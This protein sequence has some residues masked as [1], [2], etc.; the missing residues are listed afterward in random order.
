[1]GLFIFLPAT[2]K[3]DFVPLLPEVLP[4]LLKGLSDPVEAVRDVAFRAC[5]T[6]TA[7]YGKQH[8]GALLPDLEASIFAADWRVRLAS[9]QL[10][11]PPSALL[12][13][14]LAARDLILRGANITNLP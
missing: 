7:L 2:M 13:S 11:G 14:S 9:I 12:A 1:M 6:L 8:S 5:Q 4:V 10:L 3:N